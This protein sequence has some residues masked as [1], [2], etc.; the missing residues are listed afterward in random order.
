MQ[1][2]SAVSIGPHSNPG[3]VLALVGV[4]VG[5]RHRFRGGSNLG[6]A[7]HGACRFPGTG[8]PSKRFLQGR[9]WCTLR[10]EPTEPEESGGY[11]GRGLEGDSS[12]QRPRHSCARARLTSNDVLWIGHV[13]GNLSCVPKHKAISSQSICTGASLLGICLT[14]GCQLPSVSF[15]FLHL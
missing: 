9:L 15:R 13:L 14:P 1:S 10:Q 3:S 2:H 5:S 12:K 11:W 7:L 6:S 4:G 8:A